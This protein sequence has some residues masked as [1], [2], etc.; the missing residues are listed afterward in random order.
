MFISTTKP[1]RGPKVRQCNLENKLVFRGRYL[2][3]E[4]GVFSV[5]SLT[6]ADD[7][8][9]EAD[10]LRILFHYLST[11]LPALLSV[12][13]VCLCVCLSQSVCLSV[14]LQ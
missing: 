5:Y 7:S 11:D 14:S 9:I 6:E 2:N 13:S 4:V 3:Y 1:V 12:L 8:L 10:A